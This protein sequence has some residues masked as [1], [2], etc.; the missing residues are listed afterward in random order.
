MADVQ[1]DEH[2]VGTGTLFAKS[3]ASIYT[4]PT[5]PVEV[6]VL[7]IHAVQMP[8]SEE[9]PIV[10]CVDTA[11]NLQTNLGHSRKPWVACASRFSA[12]QLFKSI[13]QKYKVSFQ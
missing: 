3:R 1:C 13:C 8:L 5:M 11:S 4:F 12:R 6:A 9:Q 7:V 2:P 10:K